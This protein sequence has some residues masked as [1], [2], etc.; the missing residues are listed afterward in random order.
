MIELC[1]KEN[2]NKNL[3]FAYS[4]ILVQCINLGEKDDA[5]EYAHLA[6][7]LVSKSKNYLHLCHSNLDLGL[8]YSVKEKY[9]IA[10]EYYLKGIKIAEEYEL[11]NEIAEGYRRLSQISKASDEIKKSIDKLIHS[12]NLLKNTGFTAK[13][14]LIYK[15]IAFL[16]EKID[17]LKNASKFHSMSDSINKFDPK[18]KISHR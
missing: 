8:V 7:K 2:D 18:L 16:Y 15:Q 11:I 6:E 5:F 17:D 12:A 1:K 13:L 9:S 4:A 14:S 3:F 10:K